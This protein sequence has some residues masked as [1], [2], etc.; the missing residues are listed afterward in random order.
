MMWLLR[1]VDPLLDRFATKLAQKIEPE[2]DAAI[3]AALDQTEDRIRQ[4]LER[5]EARL[6]SAVSQGIAPLMNPLQEFW[7]QGPQATAS[8]RIAE[9]LGISPQQALPSM[10]EL[11]TAA[12]ADG[13]VP[14]TEF[15]GAIKDAVGDAAAVAKSEILLKMRRNTGTNPSPSQEIPDR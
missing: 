9:E 8:L 2:L 3:D 14:V 12:E 6:L 10:A 4:I 5:V 1:L 15:K 13:M 11:Q 7:K